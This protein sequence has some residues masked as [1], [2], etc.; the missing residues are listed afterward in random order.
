MVLPLDILCHI[1]EKYISL[2]LGINY[3]EMK[4]WN[5]VAQLRI[6]KVNPLG[7]LLFG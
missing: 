4:K 5:F 6:K 7:F 3:F 1:L 2:T